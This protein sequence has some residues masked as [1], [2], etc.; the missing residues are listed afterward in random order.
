GGGSTFALATPSPFAISICL[1]TIL[2]AILST[3]GFLL[4]LRSFRYPM[5]R[6]ARLHSIAVAFACIGWTVF[7]AYWGM[8][9]LRFWAI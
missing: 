8:I 5:N 1:L 2:Y 3:A 7:L 6:A 4:A 9:G